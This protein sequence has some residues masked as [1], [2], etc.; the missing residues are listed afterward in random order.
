MTNP[1]TLTV[2]TPC[3]NEEDS[4]PAYFKK[5]NE[6]RT[7]LCSRGW[8][9]E[10]LLIND[11]SQDRTEELLTEYAAHHPQT[12]LINHPRN[13]GYGGALKTAFSLVKTEWLAFVDADS[14]YDQRLILAMVDKI[15]ADVDIVNVSIFAPGGN[16]G[17]PWYR[18]LF[19]SSASTLYRFLLPWLTRGIYTM[20]CGFRLYRVS[21]LPELIPQGDNFYATTEVLV[22]AL[23]SRMKIIELPATN[24]P[25]DFGVSKMKFFRVALGHLR[26]IGRVWMRRLGR[27]FSALEH[28]TWLGVEA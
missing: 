13:R 20:T 25:R 1:S 18:R 11:G 27:P 17:F 28:R 22:R 23:Q 24:N 7:E 3:Y 19:S 15:S 6:L 2:A 9:V 14:N 12:R 10:V 16:V 26:L 8:S 5:I 21:R 4:L